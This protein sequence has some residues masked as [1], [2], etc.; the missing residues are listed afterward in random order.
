MVERHSWNAG[1]QFREI[2]ATSGRSGS[3]P[4]NS[5]CYAVG[6]E[7]I[8]IALHFGEIVHSEENRWW[9]QYSPDYSPLA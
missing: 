5:P 3:I 8:G 1:T 2:I 6:C 7:P 9:G 4:S